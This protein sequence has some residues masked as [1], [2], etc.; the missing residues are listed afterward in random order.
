MVIR[1]ACS[2]STSG[3]HDGIIA[4]INFVEADCDIF[5]GG[6]GDVFAHKVGPNW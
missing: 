3:N 2:Y 5:T 1:Q 4:A 6:S